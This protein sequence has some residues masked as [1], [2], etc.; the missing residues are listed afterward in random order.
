[1]VGRVVVDAIEGTLDPAIAQK[2]AID[3]KHTTLDLSRGMLKP[4]DLT[5][6]QLCTPDDLLP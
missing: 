4:V 3:R 1:M 5:T 6:D 2:F